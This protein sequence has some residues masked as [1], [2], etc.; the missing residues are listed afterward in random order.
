MYD[1]RCSKGIAKPNPV[2]LAWATFPLILVM[3][4]ACQT[5]GRA[6]AFGNKL[7]K[8]LSQSCRPRFSFAENK[9]FQN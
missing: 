9:L 4:A 3:R 2:V 5:P 1:T 7:K 6:L 8:L